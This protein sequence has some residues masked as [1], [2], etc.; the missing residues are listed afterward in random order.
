[1]RLFAGCANAKLVGGEC[2]FRG[3]GTC[4]RTPSVFLPT[5]IFDELF[6]SS[7]FRVV[8]CWLK[9]KGRDSSQIPG[10]GTENKKKKK[11]KQKKNKK[12][13]GGG[14]TPCHL[15]GFFFRNVGEKQKNLPQGFGGAGPAKKGGPANL[16]FW[17]EE[18]GAGA[19]GAGPEG[20]V[21]HNLG[22]TNHYNKK[23]LIRRGEKGKLNGLACFWGGRGKKKKKTKKK[24][25]KTKQTG[26]WGEKGR[27]HPNGWEGL[28]PAYLCLDTSGK[29]GENARLISP[30]SLC[31]SLSTKGH[32]HS[33]V[34]AA[35]A[36]GVAGRVPTLS[37]N[38]EGTGK[39]N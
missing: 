9:G 30:L 26:S 38:T 36:L 32:L 23:R 22:P 18:T 8:V 28:E 34:G 10:W 37:G 25:K 1:V 15:N 3:G 19:A 39:I 21:I 5:R 16:D 11:K 13:G 35:T 24:K 12:G 2:S 17:C 4:G 27:I 33:L 14:D 29:G 20:P 7:P 31:T 6:S